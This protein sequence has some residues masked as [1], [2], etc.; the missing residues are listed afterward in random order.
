MSKEK[1][2]RPL[3]RAIQGWINKYVMEQLDDRFELVFTGL[4]A[5]TSQEELKMNVDKVKEFMTINEVRALYEL[6]PI[7]NG[8]TILDP[9]FMQNF[10]SESGDQD[11]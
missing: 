2:L 9:S 11:A 6:E 4:D 7:A 3:L 8:D 5:I 10:G 1:G